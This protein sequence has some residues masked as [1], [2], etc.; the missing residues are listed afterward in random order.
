MNTSE[1]LE[2]LNDMFLKIKNVSSE[3]N[4]IFNCYLSNKFNFLNVRQIESIDKS[5]TKHF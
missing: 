2:Q 3:A 1:K 5:Y 4:Y